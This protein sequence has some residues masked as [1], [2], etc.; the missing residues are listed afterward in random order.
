[1]RLPDAHVAMAP[2]AVSGVAVLDIDPRRGGDG[3]RCDL[4][5]WCMLLPEAVEAIHRR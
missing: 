5:V 4:A 3:S 2:G 1:M